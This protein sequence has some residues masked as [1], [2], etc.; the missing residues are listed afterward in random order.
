MDLFI[1]VTLL[2]LLLLLL[3]C[4]LY[5]LLYIIQRHSW[6][7]CVMLV[8]AR[9]HERRKELFKTAFPFSLFC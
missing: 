5:S 3:F 7:W 2:L 8:Q 1:G 4:L 9:V 6:V